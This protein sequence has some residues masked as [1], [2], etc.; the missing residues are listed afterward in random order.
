MRA[1][2]DDVCVRV[3]CHGTAQA[4]DKVRRQ[5]RASR[6]APRGVLSYRVALSSSRRSESTNLVWG[7]QCDR[8]AFA[9]LMCV[10]KGTYDVVLPVAVSAGKKAAAQQHTGT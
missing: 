4:A 6:P 2:A 1:R 10:N 7:K 9:Q 8:L 5:R 3:R